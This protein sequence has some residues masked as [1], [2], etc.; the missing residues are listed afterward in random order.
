[1]DLAFQEAAMENL[2]FIS[3]QYGALSWILG[4]KQEIKMG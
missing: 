1:M 4:W 2:L 3:D